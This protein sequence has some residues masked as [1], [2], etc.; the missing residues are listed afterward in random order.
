MCRYAGAIKWLVPAIE[1]LDHGEDHVRASDDRATY[2][3]VC[4][5]FKMSVVYVNLVHVEDTGHFPQ[6]G[7]AGSFHAIGCA[8]GIDVVGVYAVFVDQTIGIAT[9]E[10]PQARDIGT[11]RGELHC[12]VNTRDSHH[13]RRQL[14]L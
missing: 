5:E 4:Y 6:N 14:T 11:I 7:G 10:L 1:G 9:R 3:I 8:D 2:H 12:G 13:A